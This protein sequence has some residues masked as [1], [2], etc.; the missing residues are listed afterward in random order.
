MTCETLSPKKELLDQ[1]LLFINLG[2]RTEY[3]GEINIKGRVLGNID[4]YTNFAG[5]ACSGSGDSSKKKV[6]M[7]NN[8]SESA[9]VSDRVLS[10][11]LPKKIV[12]VQPRD[13]E[14]FEKNPASPLLKKLGEDCPYA[15]IAFGGDANTREEAVTMFVAIDQSPK[16]VLREM[17][18][19]IRATKPHLN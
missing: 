10:V 1:Y 6:E 2:K 15:V 12:V 5:I 17:K 7:I 13:F 8:K 9:D 11:K 3:V 14:N 4:D 18:A 16:K 19:I